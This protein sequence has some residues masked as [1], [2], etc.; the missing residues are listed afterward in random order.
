MDRMQEPPLDPSIDR[1][2]AHRER[3]ELNARHH[4]VLPLS[5]DGNRSLELTR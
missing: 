3:P 2:P 4:P 1:I 5:E